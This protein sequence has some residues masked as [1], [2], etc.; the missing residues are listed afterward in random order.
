MNKKRVFHNAPAPLFVEALLGEERD[1]G[2]DNIL[3]ASAASYHKLTGADIQQCRSDLEAVSLPDD[4][5][6]RGYNLIEEYKNRPFFGIDSKSLRDFRFE[7]KS[8]QERILKLAYMALHSVIRNKSFDKMTNELLLVLMSGYKVPGAPIHPSLREYKSI[9]KMRKL[10]ELLTQYYNV[11]FYSRSRGWFFSLTLTEDELRQ[12][13]GKTENVIDEGM[14]P[15]PENEISKYLGIIAEKDAKIAELQKRVSELSAKIDELT[16][17]KAKKTAFPTEVNKRAKEIFLEF[18]QKMHPET[19]YY[20]EAK[21]GGQM[22]NL[23]KKL[24]FAK[25]EKSE[26]CTD[27]ELLNALRLF[28]ENIADEW[29]LNK[30][31]VSL[32][33]S[34]FN[35]LLSGA[36]NNY[37]RKKNAQ[38]YEVSSEDSGAYN[39]ENLE[40]WS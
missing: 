5:I 16:N 24:K 20:W 38:D 35:E 32:V 21:D 2:F 8:D 36:R 4:A 31:S 9:Y 25:T 27:D 29:V 12:K 30:L 28:L 1:I 18:Y 39:N 14:K 10:K 11:S 17:Q 15:Q 3:C 6:I 34:K 33:S 40:G 13:L 23:L 26:S 7:Y 19:P 22:T 37:S